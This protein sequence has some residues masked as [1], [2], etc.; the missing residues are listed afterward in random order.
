M[1]PLARE[2]LSPWTIQTLLEL[3]SFTELLGVCLD[4]NPASKKAQVNRTSVGISVP[5]GSYTEHLGDLGRSAC[6]RLQNKQ[7]PGKQGNRS[8]GNNGGFGELG[9]KWFA[10][11][12]GKNW[13]PGW[14]YPAGRGGKRCRVSTK[15][16]TQKQSCWGASS[17]SNSKFIASYLFQ[18]RSEGISIPLRGHLFYTCS[19]T[20]PPKN[21]LKAGAGRFVYLAEGKK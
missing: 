2:G 1:E 21:K 14:L 17:Q 6:W 8:S 5:C 18:H 9:R 7:Q 11:R 15:T 4:H 13:A 20:G 10:Q 16:S 3:L 12:M 19:W